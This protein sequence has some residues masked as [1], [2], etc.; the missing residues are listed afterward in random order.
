[1]LKRIVTAPPPRDNR[2]RCPLRTS[3]SISS[4]H[5]AIFDQMRSTSTRQS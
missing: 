5:T 1:M 2:V 3:I 4:D